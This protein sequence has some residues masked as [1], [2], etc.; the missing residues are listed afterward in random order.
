VDASR[1]ITLPGGYIRTWLNKLSLRLEMRVL[2]L[3]ATIGLVGISTAVAQRNNQ[4]K[5][6]AAMMKQFVGM[7]RLVGNRQRLADGTI[8]QGTLTVGYIIYTDTNRMCAVDMNPH[9]PKWTVEN[10]NWNTT[11]E[12]EALSA[13]SGFD[14]Y[15]ATVEINAQEAFVL[16]HVEVAAKPNLIGTTRKRSFTFEGPNRILLRIDS[17]EL[18]A[19]VVEYTLSWERVQK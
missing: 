19:P 11:K 5:A 15:C 6:D 16:H 13:M 18:Q 9:P 12:S 2:L 7:W 10:P 1:A 17:A 14:A 4:S 8:R 3:V